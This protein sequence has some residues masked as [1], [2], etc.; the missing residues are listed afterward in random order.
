MQ[1]PK[2]K[3]RMKRPSYREAVAWVAENDSGG[4]ADALE[5]TVVS[6]L[7]TACLVADLFGV[8]PERVGQDVVKYRKKHP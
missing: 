5:P 1:S 7:V 8:E 4:S 6:E 3:K 2:S